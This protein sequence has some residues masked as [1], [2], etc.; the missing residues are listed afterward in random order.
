MKTPQKWT[1][2]LATAALSATLAV[3]TV[4]LDAS[5]ASHAA[6]GGTANVATAA[7]ATSAIASVHRPSY[8]ARSMMSYINSERKRRGLRQLTYNPRLG[9]V[10]LN[11]SKT[12][13]RTQKLKHNARLPRQVQSYRWVGEN[14]G[15]GPTVAALHQAFMR[16]PGHRANVL[17]RAYTQ[18][19]VES[20]KDRNGRIWVTV[21]FRRP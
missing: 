15:Y 21:V 10:A 4:A 17:D 7:N 3:G 13:S 19:G 2:T 12:M 5:P 6:L 8:D 9:G 16:S 14:V 1:T 20:V 11:W 18:M